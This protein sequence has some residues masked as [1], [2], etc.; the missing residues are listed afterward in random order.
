[1]CACSLSR[2]AQRDVSIDM[3]AE[4]EWGAV[5]LDPSRPLLAQKVPP[6]HPLI[7]PLVHPLIQPSLIR[8]RR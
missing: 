1:M 6:I 2:D 5:S 3:E 4:E 7:Q 8:L